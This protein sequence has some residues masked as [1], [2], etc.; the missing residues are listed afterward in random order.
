MMF[1]REIL[2]NYK[3]FETLVPV[4]FGDGHTVSVL[5]SG[6]VK[7]ESQLYHNKKVAGSMTDVL[8]VPKL[9]SNLFSVNAATLKGTEEPLNNVEI[10]LEN[11]EET[12]QEN[13]LREQL[14]L[15]RHSQRAGKTPISYGVDKYTEY[16]YYA[17]D[18]SIKVQ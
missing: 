18:E 17:A 14:Q 1:Q 7:N 6:K 9:T 16:D 5:G 12:E 15:V 8:Y 10:D 3:E 2:Y 11:Y 13:I 4:G